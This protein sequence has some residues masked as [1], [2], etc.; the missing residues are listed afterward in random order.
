ML[1]MAQQRYIT[2]RYHNTSSVTDML[3]HLDMELLESRRTNAQLT[4]MFRIIDNL[5]DVPAQQYLLPASSRTRATH[6]ESTDRSPPLHHTTRTA[7]FHILSL[8]GTHCHQLWLKPLTWYPS[9]RGCPT[10]CIKSAVGA[11]HK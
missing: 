2:N 6:S 5:V 9:N 11:S 8:H 1:E 4:M 3:D 7:F 10:S